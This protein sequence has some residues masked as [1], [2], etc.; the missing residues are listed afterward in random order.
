MTDSIAISIQGVSLGYGSHTVLSQVNLTVKSGERI[1]ITGANGSGKSTLLKLVSGNLIERTGSVQ[2]LGTQITC[3][4][5]RQALR[6][7]IGVLT[8]VQQDPK[9]AITVQESVLLGLWGARF[10]WLNRPK[11]IDHEKA[12]E[13]LASVDMTDFARR[14]IRTLSGGQRQRVALARAL[15]RDPQLVLMDE[16]TTYLDTA[17]KE[18]ILD[19]IEQLQR[20]LRFTSLVVSHESLGTR[21]SDRQIHISGGTLQYDRGVSV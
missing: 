13:R 3:G 5:D 18:D 7:Q 20:Q 11:R 21:L 10:S 9:I 12:L 15:I 6:K 14:D 4:S 2:I 16:P 8:Q 19:R 1:L 17:A